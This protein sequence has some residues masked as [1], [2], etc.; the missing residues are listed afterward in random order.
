MFEVITDVTSRFVHLK[1]EEEFVLPIEDGVPVKDV[2][3]IINGHYKVDGKPLL[4][5]N[6][7]CSKDYWNK[8]RVGS[9]FAWGCFKS[10]YEFSEEGKEHHW[11]I[12]SVS[13][14]SPHKYI[15]QCVTDR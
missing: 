1:K 13:L 8:L 14:T 3:L 10:D 4:R 6:F 2:G 5:L 9:S 15:V 11:K 7:S 12:D